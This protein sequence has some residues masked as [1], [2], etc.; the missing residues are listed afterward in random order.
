MLA[1]GRPRSSSSTRAART[2]RCAPSRSTVQARSE[3]ERGSDGSRV[4]HT[5]FVL[6]VWSKLVCHHRGPEPS[7][8]KYMPCLCPTVHHITFW[9]TPWHSVRAAS[10]G[11]PGGGGARPGSRSGGTQCVRHTTRTPEYRHI[12]P[13]TRPAPPVPVAWVG[14]ALARKAVLPL[15]AQTAT[16][17]QWHYPPF[18]A[19][20]RGRSC[21]SC[22]PLVP[23]LRRPRPGR[24]CSRPPPA[25]LRRPR[26]CAAPAPV[27]VQHFASCHCGPWGAHCVPARAAAPLGGGRR[28][29]LA[30]GRERLFPPRSTAPIARR[31]PPLAAT[32]RPTWTACVGV[33]TPPIAPTRR[34]PAGAPTGPG[35]LRRPRTCPPAGQDTVPPADT[36]KR[37]QQRPAPAHPAPTRSTHSAA[38]LMSVPCLALQCPPRPSASLLPHPPGHLPAA[39][40]RHAPSSAQPA[41]QIAP[42][43]GPQHSALAPWP[44]N[45]FH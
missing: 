15:P 27:C 22:R 11:R 13:R 42:M 31:A 24:P 28:P 7:S 32:A 40:D 37:R 20:A 9:R 35:A 26:P 36:Q 14:R 33:S 41:M 25:R 18:P 19:L 29:N 43:L 10:S 2:Q 6:R 17:R 5:M 44:I 45:P 34:R 12:A 39:C 16:A 38:R 8:Q 4:V 3:R 21:C 1:S 30:N 23:A